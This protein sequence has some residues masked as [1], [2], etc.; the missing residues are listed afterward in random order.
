[1]I[2][3]NKF[4]IKICYNQGCQSESESEIRNP[5]IRGISDKFM[6]IN[7]NPKSEKNLINKSKE[8]ELEKNI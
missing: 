2:K 8:S 6:A 5:T 7:P 3:S 4:D 1:M